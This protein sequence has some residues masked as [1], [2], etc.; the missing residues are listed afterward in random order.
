MDKHIECDSIIIDYIVETNELLNQLENLIINAEIEE[1]LKGYIDK[2]IRIIHTIKG[3]SMT[4]ELD[5][6]VKLMHLEEDIICYL[7]DN[8]IE[9][10]D[11][12]NLADIFLNTIDYIRR[13]T[14]K[15]KNK[16]YKSSDNSNL[17]KDIEKFSKSFI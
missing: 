3:N 11:Y 2:I 9:N 1:S 5:N 15:L 12:S 4:M 16:N 17:I 13:E 6:I 10:I 7:R 8:N 14:L